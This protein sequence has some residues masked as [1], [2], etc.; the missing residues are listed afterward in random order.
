MA[1]RRCH[2]ATTA[3][4]SPSRKTVRPS[5][6]FVRPGSGMI[7]CAI[8][9]TCRALSASGS[10]R[11][12]RTSRL[13]SRYRGPLRRAD[14]C[15]PRLAFLGRG[16]PARTLFSSRVRIFGIR[17]ILSASISS[18]NAR[19]STASSR[20]IVAGDAFWRCRTAMNCRTSA[21]VTECARR[22]PDVFFGG[23]RIEAEPPPQLTIRRDGGG[24]QPCV[25]SACS[26]WI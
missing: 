5:P 13:V 6:P 16:S 21:A 15:A 24:A 9:S 14:T 11:G 25:R 17:W 26:S 23:D 4:A 19:R 20:L 10:P 7:A 18:R 3:H 8:T 2:F 1:R 12:T 22:R